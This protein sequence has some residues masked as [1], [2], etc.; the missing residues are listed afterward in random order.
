MSDLDWMRDQLSR[1]SYKPGWSFDVIYEHGVMQLVTRYEAADSRYP[2][3]RLVLKGHKSLPVTADADVF[4]RHVFEGIMN[5]ERHEAQEWFRRDGVLF[6]DPHADTGRWR[7]C[8]GAGPKR[9]A[10]PQWTCPGCG[11]AHTNAEES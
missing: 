1:C 11:T 4:A 3:R 5:A 6:D 2:D 9:D 7:C 8:G 10:S